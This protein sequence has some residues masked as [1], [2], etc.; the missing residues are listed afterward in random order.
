MATERCK[1]GSS[2]VF[3][4]TMAFILSYRKPKSSWNRLMSERRRS[5]SIPQATSKAQDTPTSRLLT[6]SEIP[7]WYQ[8]NR[9]IT[10]GYRPLLYSSCACLKSVFSLHNETLNIWTHLLPATTFT[11]LQLVLQV[12]I[13]VRFPEANTLDRFVFATNLASAIICLILS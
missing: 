10:S 7:H 12:A 5:I 11:G 1:L 6:W 13:D 4:I 9:I 8:D 3:L 2:T